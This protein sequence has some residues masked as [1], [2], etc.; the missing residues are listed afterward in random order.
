MYRDPIVAE[1][2]KAGAALARKANY[3][4]HT[5]FE[6]LRRKE[7]ARENGAAGAKPGRKAAVK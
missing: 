3:D 6:I 5:Y 2:R 1:V 7:A 4:V